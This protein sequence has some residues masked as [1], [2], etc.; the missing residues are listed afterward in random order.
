FAPAGEVCVAVIGCYDVYSTELPVSLAGVSEER[1]FSP[2]LYEHPLPSISVPLANHDFGEVALGNLVNLEV[3]IE[4]V[5][6][7]PLEGWVSIVGSEHITVFPEY[8]AA[9]VGNTDGVMLTFAPEALEDMS[10]LLVIESN[11]PVRPRIEIPL[12]GAGFEEAP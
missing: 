8:F 1:A 4:N 9:S 10:A 6:L 12:I 2:Q 3:P 11:D 5:G 7:L